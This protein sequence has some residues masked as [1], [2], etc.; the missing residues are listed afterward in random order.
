MLDLKKIYLF[1]AIS[2]NASKYFLS[3]C[4]A[5]VMFSPLSLF[6]FF[7]VLKEFRIMRLIK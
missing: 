3:L 5:S 6:F 7:L 2:V 1:Y 4:W